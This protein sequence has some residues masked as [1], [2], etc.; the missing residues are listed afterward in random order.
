[1]ETREIKLTPRRIVRWYPGGSRVVHENI[2]PTPFSRERAEDIWEARRGLEQALTM[3][4]EEEAYV[5]AVWDT[6]SGSS[7]FMSAFHVIRGGKY[8]V[9]K[10]VVKGVDMR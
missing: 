4:L 7:S 5:H 8:L 10:G 9:N 3:T 2:T 1:M 6:M